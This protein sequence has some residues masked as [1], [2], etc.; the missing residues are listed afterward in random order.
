MYEEEAEEGDD[1]EAR[2]ERVTNGESEK[3]YEEGCAEGLCQNKS[4]ALESGASTKCHLCST[5]RIDVTSDESCDD[6]A[7]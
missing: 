6:R 5:D 3:R 2:T 7:Y 1:S 4:G